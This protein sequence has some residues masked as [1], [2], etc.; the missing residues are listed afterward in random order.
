[1]KSKETNKTDYCERDWTEVL[2]FQVFFLISSLAAF[3]ALLSN[4]ALFVTL[5]LATKHKK[6]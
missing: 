1:M 5:T 3:S 2:C 6:Q 4:F